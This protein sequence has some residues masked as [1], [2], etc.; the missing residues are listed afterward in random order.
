MQFIA[1]VLALVVPVVSA[2]KPA[3][4]RERFTFPAPEQALSTPWFMEYGARISIT[5][6]RADKPLDR[7]AT[8]EGLCVYGRS[9]EFRL[10]VLLLLESSG[11]VL[12]PVGVRYL[13][14]RS[15]GMRVEGYALTGVRGGPFR[16]YRF[17]GGSWTTLE[18]PQ[19]ALEE[20]FVS[21]TARY[22]AA[23]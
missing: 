15:D 16:F 3:E 8:A 23:Q 2:Q 11:G 10:S 5:S 6:P 21:A 12:V 1:I 13:L 19:A 4:F 20:K 7:Y 14:D 18:G 22:V 17:R 9:C